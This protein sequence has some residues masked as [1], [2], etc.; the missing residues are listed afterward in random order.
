MKLG[1]C[2]PLIALIMMGC[3]GEKKHGNNETETNQTTQSVSAK[4]HKKG[5]VLVSIPQASGIC[6]SHQRKTLFVANDKG[7]IYEISKS[8]EILRK[9]FL[10]QEFMDKKYDL[11]GV[12]CDDA[13]GELFF[14]QEGKDNVLVV[15]QEDLSLKRKIK[16]HRKYQGKVVLSKDKKHGLEA[17]AL[18]DDKL[19]LSNQSMHKHSKTD[20]SVLIMI[21]KDSK[22]KKA[23]ITRILEHGQKDISGLTYHEGKLYMLSDQKNKLLIYD[24]KHE[25]VLKKIKLPHFAQEGIAFDD[26]G[27]LYLADDNGAVLKYK[28]E[29]FGL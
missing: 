3:A 24:V 5:A 26:E 23:R 7:Y 19:I 27:Y 25:K 16:I 29:R 17:I 11:E 18:M 4:A 20:L 1:L 21:D 15:S 6:F 22:G 2:L 13:H 14:A 8:G 9:Q 10:D 12:T 28:K